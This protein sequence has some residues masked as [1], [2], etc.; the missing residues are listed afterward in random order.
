MK[1]KYRNILIGIIILTFVITLWLQNTDDNKYHIKRNTIH[2]KYKF[3]FFW[4]SCLGLGFVLLKLDV[5]N[6]DN[7]NLVKDLPS[8][9]T[10]DIY[11]EPFY[12]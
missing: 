3:P 12:R 11:I 5:F 10:Q 6:H 4:S 8:S 7:K 9:Y 1:D 2:D